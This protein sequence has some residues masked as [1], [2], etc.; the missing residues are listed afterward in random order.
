VASILAVDPKDVGLSAQKT[1]RHAAMRTHEKVLV[2][3][4]DALMAKHLNEI[5]QELGLTVVHVST[6][7]QDAV[8]T[9]LSE[10]PAMLLV[11][12][13]LRQ[14]ETGLRAALRILQRLRIP[15]IFVTGFPWLLEADGDLDPTFVVEKPFRS[16]T[17]KARIALMLEIYSVESRAEQRHQML[18]KTLRHLTSTMNEP[19]LAA[20]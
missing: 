1:R 18:L 8:R 3:E 17:L 5:T 20:S 7:V 4:D 14:G 13:Q 15:V 16:T 11:D 9:A 10:K 12:V 6:G 2:I 19:S